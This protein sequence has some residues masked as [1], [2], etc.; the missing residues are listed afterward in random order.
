MLFEVIR[1]LA[2]AV[3]WL[4]LLALK[5]DLCS[6]SELW[7]DS[8]HLQNCSLLLLCRTYTG[9]VMVA[10]KFF[11]QLIFRHVLSFI[12]HARFLLFF[13]TG[14]DMA[15]IKYFQSLLCLNVLLLIWLM[16]CITGSQWFPDV[17]SDCCCHN[18]IEK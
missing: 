13:Y 12:F 3:L 17:A 10:N 2:F 11:A 15:C 14:P 9:T 5:F 1:C 4:L 16:F 18:K 8:L 6:G 7:C